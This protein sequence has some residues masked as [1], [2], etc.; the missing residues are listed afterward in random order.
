MRKGTI[1]DI[2][3]NGKMAR[4]VPSNNSEIVTLP[5]VI[6]FYWRAEMGNLQ[7]GDE[8]YYNEDESLGGY[9]YGRTDGEWDFTVRT[10]LTITENLDVQG[11][12]STNGNVTA[13]GD[14]TAS[15]I[16]LKGHTH[17]GVEGGSGTTQKPQ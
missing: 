7:I 1:H 3:E 6:P 12:I 4:V 17:G 10:S 11:N 2:V 9:I 13:D 5:L 15:G 16:S 8:V 14:V